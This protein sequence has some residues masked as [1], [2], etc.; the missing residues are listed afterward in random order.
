M[1]A[2]QGIAG[3][4]VRTGKILN[5]E[6]APSHSLFYKGVEELNDFK[7]RNIL[8]FPIKDEQGRNSA[9]DTPH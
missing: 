9:V 3:Y 4:V 5:I 2:T 6:D 1:S 7:T 8:C